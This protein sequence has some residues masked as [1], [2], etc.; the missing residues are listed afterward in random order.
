MQKELD[1][2]PKEGFRVVPRTLM[3]KPQA[4]VGP[5]IVVVLERPPKPDQR[6]EYL[7]LATTLTSTLQKEWAEAAGR[8][9]IPADMV[10]RGELILIMERKSLAK[11]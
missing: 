11:E 6:Y 3:S 10:T 9:F 5:E 7:V 8:G 4:F 2:A 1:A